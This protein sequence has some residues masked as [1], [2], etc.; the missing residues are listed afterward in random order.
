VSFGAHVLGRKQRR[1]NFKGKARYRVVPAA[2]AKRA[3]GG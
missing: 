1:E 3:A 2:T